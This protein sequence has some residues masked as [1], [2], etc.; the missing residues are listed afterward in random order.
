MEKEEKKLVFR[1]LTKDEI[2]V[3]VQSCGVSKDDT[4][5]ARLLLYK[6]ARV[7]MELLDET[8]GPEN[9]QREH[10]ELKGNI[11]CGVS[12]K[13]PHG[14][15]FYW[16]TKWD[17]GAESNTEKEKG[18]ASDSFKRACV[19]WGI[20]RELYTKIPI[21]VFGLPKNAKGQVDGTFEVEAIKIENKEIIGLSLFF[22]KGKT[23][24]RCFAWS[25]EKGVVQS[26]MKE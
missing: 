7:D 21:M 1:D 23:K 17:C 8:V 2:D 15:G 26:S 10:K 9:W 4:A 11:Y 20:G 5:W 13:F 24:T 22:V 3:R 18:E 25:K 16:V 12:I 14:D 19:N 6:D